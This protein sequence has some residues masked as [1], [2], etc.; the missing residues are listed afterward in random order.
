MT[1]IFTFGSA[2]SLASG[3]AIIQGSACGPVLSGLSMFGNTFRIS[4]ST[5]AG[6]CSAFRLVAEHVQPTLEQ[7]SNQLPVEGGSRHR[8]GHARPLESGVDVP[9][10]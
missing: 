5:T 1:W 6:T 4:R 3:R 7:G 10:G 9:G 8:G 2:L